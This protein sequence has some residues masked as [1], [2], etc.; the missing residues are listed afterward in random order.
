MK[1]KEKK[2][3]IEPD[4]GATSTQRQVANEEL[5]RAIDIYREHGT[6]A[7]EIIQLLQRMGD[8][9]D[10]TN[11]AGVSGIIAGIEERR[12]QPNARFLIGDHAPPYLAAAGILG[13]RFADPAGAAKAAEME[14][15]GW[16]NKLR[17]FVVDSIRNS[18]A[19]LADLHVR[20][21]DDM[22]LLWG[23]YLVSG[24]CTLSQ[25]FDRSPGSIRY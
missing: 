4:R 24:E 3:V 11:V 8:K 12:G 22:D 20:S 1:E 14:S 21:P 5:D 18:P 16:P 13:I 19:S 17:D 25:D 10:E 2:S 9:I 7:D 15:S 6:G 23:A